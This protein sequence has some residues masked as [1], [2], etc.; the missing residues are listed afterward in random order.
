[1]A[2]RCTA[3]HLYKR[4]TQ[5][6]F[7]EGAAP[8]PLMLVGEQ[9][10]NEED[11]KGHPFVGP[12][13]KVL[14]KAL[15][16][17]G[18]QRSDVFMTNAVKHF[19]WEPR[20]KTRLH[21]KPNSKE[22]QACHPWLEAEVERVNPRLIIALGATAGTAV[23]GRVPRIGAERGKIQ[24]GKWFEAAVLVTWHPSV[25][26]RS[27]THEEREQRL[28]ELSV[29]IQ[30]ALRHSRKLKPSSSPKRETPR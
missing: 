13:G 10:G 7:G 24:K 11:L 26:L 27:R 19:K 8:A 2:C 17:A 1:M 22:V 14:D 25:I 12:A 9:P 23:L 15:A 30:L 4:G 21:K 29:D 6:V 16:M 20:G 3:C 28:K 18:L 5:T